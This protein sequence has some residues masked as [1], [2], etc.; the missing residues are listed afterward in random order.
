VRVNCAEHARLVLSLALEARRRADQR[1]LR[2]GVGTLD[3][4]DKHLPHI[5]LVHLSFRYVWSGVFLYLYFYARRSVKGL[6]V[7]RHS[8]LL[9][10][11]QFDGPV[12]VLSL[13][14]ADPVGQHLEKLLFEV[15]ILVRFFKCLH[16]VAEFEIYLDTA[17]KDVNEVKCEV[18]IVELQ[19]FVFVKA[20]KVR[21]RHLHEVS[22]DHGVNFFQ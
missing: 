19:F 17:F 8:L 2:I 20:L 13:G 6:F 1:F 21:V 15:L 4:C 10:V 9:E 11:V 12:Y 18:R 5:D 16:Q 3:W 7:A 22:L 14:L